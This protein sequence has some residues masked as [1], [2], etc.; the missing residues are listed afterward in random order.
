MAEGPRAGELEQ[1]VEG[2]V[3]IMSRAENLLGTA[4]PLAEGAGKNTGRSLHRVLHTLKTDARPL[5]EVAPHM[6]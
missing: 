2:Q 3:G 1:G 5:Y 6:K 4:Q